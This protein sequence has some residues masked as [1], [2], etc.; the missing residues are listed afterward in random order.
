MLLSLL[1]QDARA[2][3]RLRPVRLVHDVLE[4]LEFAVV[5]DLDVA[6]MLL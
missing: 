6:K 4:L 2:D 5:G 3:W 1:E